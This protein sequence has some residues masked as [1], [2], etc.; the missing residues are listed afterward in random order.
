M[1]IE[2]IATNLLGSLMKSGK[3][4]AKR[5]IIPEAKVL[6]NGKVFVRS[7]EKNGASTV[8]NMQLFDRAGEEIVRKTRTINKCQDLVPSNGKGYHFE[9]NG[10][11]K[12]SVPQ[13][14]SQLPVEGAHGR[15][16]DRF[17]SDGT[18][19]TVARHDT[20]YYEKY[21]R[22]D[23]SRNGNHSQIIKTDDGRLGAD[24]SFDNGVYRSLKQMPDYKSKKLRNW[25]SDY[26]L[27]VKTGKLE[28]VRSDVTWW[29][30]QESAKRVAQQNGEIAMFDWLVR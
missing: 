17:Y 18:V 14:N 24:I 8:T 13:V 21:L 2:K 5:G 19:E 6:A 3:V 22:L 9:G 15:E 30:P 12:T 7:I 28:E 26:R 4:I 23:Y 1:G 27:N 25:F 20:R 16:F 29:N 10:S 11:V